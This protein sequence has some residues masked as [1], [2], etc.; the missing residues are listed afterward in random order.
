MRGVTVSGDP[1]LI[2]DIRRWLQGA[3]IRYIR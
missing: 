2:S 1:Y 3:I